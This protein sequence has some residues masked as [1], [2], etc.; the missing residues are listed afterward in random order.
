MKNT[1]VRFFLDLRTDV[2]DR[3]FATLNLTDGG[4]V[5]VTD[6]AGHCY[7]SSDTALVGETLDVTAE[8]PAGTMLC[9][10]RSPNT[11]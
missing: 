3:L 9:P 8:A 2:F 4:I 5:Y 6:E 10:S 11:G 1:W 7:F